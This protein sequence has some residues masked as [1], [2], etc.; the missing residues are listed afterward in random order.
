VAVERQKRKRE[1]EGGHTCKAKQK[2]RRGK[3]KGRATKRS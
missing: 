1:K 3:K 2:K